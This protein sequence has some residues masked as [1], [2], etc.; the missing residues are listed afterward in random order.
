MPVYWD[1]ASFVGNLVL[2]RGIQEPTYKYML[3]NAEIVADKKA[4][5]L[6]LS[7]RIL[8]S[9]L[10]NLDLALAGHGDLVF[11]T[12]QLELAEPFLYSINPNR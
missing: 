10:S 4:F 9:T 6:A 7:A 5:E 3:N 2:F 12:R 11:A 1:L 8:L